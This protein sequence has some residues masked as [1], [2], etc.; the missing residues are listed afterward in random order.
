[1][2]RR[3]DEGDVD[4]PSRQEVQKELIRP[5]I[6]VLDRDDAIAWREKREERVADRGHPG[7][8]AR[9]G[10][11]ALELAHLVFEHGQGGFGV[12]AVD[13]T[14]H[15]LRRDIEPFVDVGVAEGDAV[16]ERQLS[17][18]LPEILLLLTSPDGL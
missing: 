5:A 8:E 17:R 6:G 16:Y 10:L 13:V 12:A 1:M 9:C 11:G 2:I 18:A 4:L 14:R 3:I 7:G 15:A